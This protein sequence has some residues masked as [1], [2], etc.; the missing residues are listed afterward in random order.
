MAGE[1]LLSGCVC[2]PL[3]SPLRIGFA[4]VPQSSRPSSHL[5]M[6]VAV[7]SRSLL[8]SAKAGDQLLTSYSV[9]PVGPRST[10]VATWP[11]EYQRD[12][13]IKITTLNDHEQ[14]G[15][16]ANAL[17]RLSE[18]AWHA[19]AWLDTSP[20]LEKGIAALIEQL[21]SPIDEI[22]SVDLATDGLRHAEA[23]SFDD[24]RGAIQKH[25]PALFNALTRTQRLTVADELAI[26]AASRAEGLQ[27]LPQGLDPES[28]SRV[29]QMCEVTRSLRYG[30]V[31]SLPEGGPSWLVRCWGDDRSP[32]ERWG[33]RD[34]LL[35]MEQLVAACEAYGGRGAIDDLGELEA[36][37]V[38]PQGDGQD[39]KVNYV[40]MTDKGLAPW[41][42]DPYERLTIFGYRPVD[43]YPDAR[44]KI[45]LGYLEPIDD[46]GFA[47]F[48]GEWTRLVPAPAHMGQLID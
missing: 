46:D 27:H 28:A 31:G 19:A 33:A 37:L 25:L 24:A 7:A 12:H 5:P 35:R 10:I 34:Q 13:S 36:H 44:E 22:G 1:R 6:P 30:Q 41:R 40:Q 8:A 16:L 43:E 15:D 26:D 39:N 47:K 18:G 3:C 11:G 38:I 4:V 20:I 29:W 2:D 45:V 48:L 17:T 42:K 21:R 14:A 9:M 32:A 23:W